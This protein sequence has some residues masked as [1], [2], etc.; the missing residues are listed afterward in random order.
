[1]FK[2]KEGFFELTGREESLWELEKYQ[3]SIKGCV[4]YDHS[5]ESRHPGW[6]GVMLQKNNISKVT[7]LT[8]QRKLCQPDGVMETSAGNIKARLGR[9]SSI[10]GYRE[11]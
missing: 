8:Q 7:R 2:S 4:G 11:E 9:V 10:T 5:G 3:L 1:M 6:G